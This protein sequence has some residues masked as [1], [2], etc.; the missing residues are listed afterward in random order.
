MRPAWTSGGRLVER[1]ARIWEVDPVDVEYN[2]GVISP[3]ERQRTLRTT[4]QGPGA[5]AERDWRAPSWEGPRSTLPECVGNAFAL[6]VV[7]V[8]VDPEDGEGGHISATRPSRMRAR[9]FIPATWRGRYR[10]ER[11]QGIG[12]A[13][14]EEYY[15]NDQAGT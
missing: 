5:A 2:G 8:E 10:A 9:P 3:Q 12:W 4:H 15:L 1:A 7:D 11:S 6:H 13:L 14:N